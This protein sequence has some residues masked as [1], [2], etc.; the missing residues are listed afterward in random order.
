LL[1]PEPTHLRGPVAVKTGILPCAPYPSSFEFRGATLLDIL[2]PLLGY[3]GSE[4][5]NIPVG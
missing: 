3:L 2:D 4:A 1:G 5:W